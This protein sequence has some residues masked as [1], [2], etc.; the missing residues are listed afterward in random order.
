[1]TVNI[2]NASIYEDNF[3][4]ISSWTDD[5]SGGGE[6]SQV[7][8]DS[9]SC[10]K[11]DTGGSA[12]GYAARV[13]DVGTFGNNNVF[14]FYSYIDSIGLTT[15]YEAFTFI[16][17]NG[18]YQLMVGF[19]SDNVRVHSTY[20]AYYTDI[21]NYVVQDSWQEWT[22]VV[23]G[24]SDYKVD[25]YLN[26]ILKNSSV[27]CRSTTV[28]SNG[29]VRFSTYAT[30]ANNRIVYVDW[31]KAG[32]ALYTSTDIGLRVSN[33]S[34]TNKINVETL[35]ASHKLRISDGSDTYGI[36]LVDVSS[37]QNSGV[38]IYDGAAIKALPKILYE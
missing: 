4:S 3:S 36:S 1:M 11:L 28:S 15:A 7:T 23:T 16:A 5:D 32:S 30:T 25:V 31:F 22:F 2:S 12:S 34:T 9:R 29:T 35:S 21:G 10:M 33:S 27:D 26:R 24:P 8:F 19:Y 20:G 13:K 17:S 18:S 37:D 14:S 6:S 38:E